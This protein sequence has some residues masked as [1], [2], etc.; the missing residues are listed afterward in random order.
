VCD[1]L[2]LFS[3][4]NTED[5]KYN[6]KEYSTQVIN[7]DSAEDRLDIIRL[8]RICNAAKRVIMITA[9]RT[10]NKIFF[11]RYAVQPYINALEKTN[12][13]LQLYNLEIDGLHPPR[14]GIEL[15]ILPRNTI[16]IIPTNSDG[17]IGIMRYYSDCDVDVDWIYDKQWLDVDDINK[18]ML[19]H[20][21]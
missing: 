6:S 20:I 16:A 5:A 15:K 18:M 1:V 2:E 9:L 12:N 10:P 4:R 17:K 14:L 13:Y 7:D 19:I 8:E 21:R 11:Y 3:I